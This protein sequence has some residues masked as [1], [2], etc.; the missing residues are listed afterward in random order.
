MFFV[1]VEPGD[2]RREVEG[3]LGGGLTASDGWPLWE[4]L[5]EGVGYYEMVILLGSDGYGAE[6]IISKHPEI[7]SELLALCQQHATKAQENIAL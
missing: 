4:V 6:I 3:V 1:V 2:T 7:D 5:E